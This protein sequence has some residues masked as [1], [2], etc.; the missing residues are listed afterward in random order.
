[1]R[2]SEAAHYGLVN[3]V[4][5]ASEVMTKAR[6]LAQELAE[7]APL[8]VAALKEIVRETEPLSVEE[9]FA[10][11]KSRKLPAYRR[12]LTSKDFREGPRAFAEKRKPIFVGR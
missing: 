6:S 2:A 8:A 4:V 12:M 9:A 5:P 11:T 1:M 3:F 7:K 10:L